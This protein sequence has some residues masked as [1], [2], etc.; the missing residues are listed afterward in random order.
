M[1]GKKLLALCS[2]LA[3]TSAASTLAVYAQLNPP[4]EVPA[5]SYN[6]QFFEYDEKGAKRYTHTDHYAV[7]GDG[8]NAMVNDALLARMGERIVNV[9]DF[10]KRVSWHAS[11]FGRTV[12]TRPMAEHEVPEVHVNECDKGEVST[13]GRYEV[14][15]ERHIVRKHD[16]ILWSVDIWR[17]PELG[18][19]P[20]RTTRYDQDGKPTHDRVAS[21]IVIGEPDPALFQVPEGYVE[22]SPMQANQKLI[23][24][25]VGKPF[26]GEGLAIMDR[27]ERRYR[28]PGR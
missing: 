9:N 7:R 20:L 24:L 12:T 19:V 11:L 23:D 6:V 28:E 15:K 8:S 3:V 27:A 25:G 1:N 10:A 14:R 5:F 4:R 26:Q 13:L 22:S 18:C 21:T 17:A 16:Q 2:G